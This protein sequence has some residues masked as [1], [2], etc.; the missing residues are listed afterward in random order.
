MM[1]LSDY[2]ILVEVELLRLG[3]AP[4]VRMMQLSRF[5]CCKLILT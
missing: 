5:D 1:I 2:L 4:L 3:A